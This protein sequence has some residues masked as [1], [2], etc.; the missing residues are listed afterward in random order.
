M[1]EQEHEK[2]RII[3]SVEEEAFPGGKQHFLKDLSAQ[4]WD[5]LGLNVPPVQTHSKKQQAFT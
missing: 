4:G 2:Q 3:A 1:T 5:T